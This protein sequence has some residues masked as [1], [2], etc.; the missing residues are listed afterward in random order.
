MGI[1]VAIILAGLNGGLACFRVIEEPTILV[2]LALNF[3]LGKC[4][5]ARGASKYARTTTGRRC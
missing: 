3:M 5:R 1:N 4:E 2:S